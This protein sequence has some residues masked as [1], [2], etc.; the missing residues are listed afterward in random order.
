MILAKRESTHIQTTQCKGLFT[1]SI[2]AKRVVQT[3]QY[4]KLKFKDGL[5]LLSND[6]DP[7]SIQEKPPNNPKA[8]RGANRPTPHIGGLKR[9]KPEQQ[10]EKKVAALVPCPENENSIRLPSRLEGI[11]FG[12][13]EYREL[14]DEDQCLVRLSTV[15]EIRAKDLDD[16]GPDEVV[17]QTMEARKAYLKYVYVLDSGE[18]L[19]D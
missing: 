11:K 13:P 10:K 15:I 12:T 8:D 17:R 6:N 19:S 1:K 2:F 16:C 4:R 9:K 14:S 18:R 3:T 7:P 5:G